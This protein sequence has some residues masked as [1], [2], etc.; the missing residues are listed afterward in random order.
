MP[1]L[2]NLGTDGVRHPQHQPLDEANKS[3]KNLD[4]HPSTDTD[5][6][7]AVAEQASPRRQKQA[8][9]IARAVQKMAGLFFG[10]GTAAYLLIYQWVVEP[11][12]PG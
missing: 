10:L 8:V 12:A 11:A 9:S 2:S 6:T 3:N 5:K 1:G 7:V 4:S